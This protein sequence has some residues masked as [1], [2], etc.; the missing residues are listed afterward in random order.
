M[1]INFLNHCVGVSTGL[2]KE[3]KEENYHKIL[4][5]ALRLLLAAE[6]AVDTCTLKPKLDS[7]KTQILLD[8]RSKKTSLNDALQIIN[9]KKEEIAKKKP[10][11]IGKKN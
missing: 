7:S 11:E 3:A 6:F 2:I 5:H 4:Y 1:S 8:I 10:N 9:S